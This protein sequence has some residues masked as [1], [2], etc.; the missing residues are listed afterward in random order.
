M[1]ITVKGNGDGLKKK[2]EDMK[3][4]VDSS[5]KAGVHAGVVILQKSAQDKCPVDTG[6]L[7]KNIKTAEELVSPGV[8]RGI[9]YVD[10]SGAPYGIYIEYGTGIY[11][12]NGDGRKTRWSYKNGDGVWVSTVGARAQPFMRPALDQDGQNAID[13]A[14]R[15]TIEGIKG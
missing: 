14:K 2:L 12:E 7:K 3:S 6:T 9:F 10:V 13:T 5:I 8:A 4:R 15:I 1:N 11:A